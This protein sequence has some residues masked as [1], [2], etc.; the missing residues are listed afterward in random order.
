MSCII[1]TDLHLIKM[2]PGQTQARSVNIDIPNVTGCDCGTNITHINVIATTGY[3]VTITAIPSTPIS[4]YCGTAFQIDFDITALP[5]APVN[6]TGYIQ[7]E[8]LR[9]SGGTT[10]YANIGVNIVP[11]VQFPNF[12]LRQICAGST[13]YIRVCNESDQPQEFVLSLCSCPDFIEPVPGDWTHAIEPCQCYEFPIRYAP[14]ISS[15]EQGSCTIN[16]RANGYQQLLYLNY[17]EVLC[18]MELSAFT[19]RDESDIININDGNFN[20]E[21]DIYELSCIGDKLTI[22]ITENIAQPLVT[23]D[24]L[25]FG[26]WLFA[27]SPNWQYNFPGQ[28]S[29]GYEYVVCDGNAPDGTFAMRFYGLNFAQK[30]GDAEVIISNNG[31]T[32]EC[33]CTFVVM[34]DVDFEPSFLPVDVSEMLLRSS[35]LSNSILSNE[36]DNSVYKNSKYMTWACSIERK[37]GTWQRDIFSIKARLN[38]YNEN[39]TDTNVILS[40]VAYELQSGDSEYLSTERTTLMRIDFK[41]SGYD[42]PGTPPDEMWLI[43]IRADRNI[44]GIDPAENYME[45]RAN[46]TG[47]VADGVILS[48]NTAPTFISGINYYAEVE[49]AQV[50][51]VS[52][53]RFI[54][55][56][57]SLTTNPQSRSSIS[58]IF[59]CIN[60]DDVDINMS[61]TIITIN[62][63]TAKRTSRIIKYPVNAQIEAELKLKVEDINSSLSSKTGGQVTDMFQSLEAIELRVSEFRDNIEIRYFNPRISLRQGK[64]VNDSEQRGLPSFVNRGNSELLNLVFPFTI[65]DNAIRNTTSE[66]WFNAG[67]GQPLPTI[68][69]CDSFI[70]NIVDAMQITGTNT[71]NLNGSAFI[72]ELNQVWVCDS[73]ND[74]IVKIDVNTNAVLGTIALTIGDT[75]VGIIYIQGFDKVYVSCGGATAIRIINIYTEAVTNA[76]G[77][78]GVSSQRFARVGNVV[79]YT[80]FTSNSVH[81]INVLNDTETATSVVGTNPIDIVYF[82]V[83]DE[84]FVGNF[85]SNNI[86]RLDLGLTPAGTIALSGQPFRLAVNGNEVLATYTNTIARI[87]SAYVVTTA[88]PTS[89]VLASIQLRAQDGLIYLLCNGQ[90]KLCILDPVTLSAITSIDI[91][92]APRDF[93]FTDSEVYINNATDA[94]ITPITFGVCPELINSPQFSFAFKDIRL[95]WIMSFSILGNRENYSYQQIL[96]RVDPKEDIVIDDIDL[97]ELDNDGITWNPI[98]YPCPETGIMRITVDASNPIN[99]LGIAVEAQPVR[100][101]RITEKSAETP[102]IIPVESEYISDLNQ[103]AGD[104]VQ[105]VFDFPAWLANGAERSPGELYNDRQFNLHILYK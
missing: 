89:G 57:K 20:P 65:P 35:I 41:Y 21:C 44:Q 55:I 49:I 64:W 50:D 104:S 28:P 17:D 88:T 90:D 34:A 96:S 5:N 100:N 47:M 52:A 98:E 45:S 2:L 26:Q 37:S 12:N 48:V 18:D 27:Q 87:S 68:N 94:T 10:L 61:S 51:D 46:L 29:Q 92:D 85:N 1:N 99:V 23:G 75:P 93:V 11:I 60:Y 70:E 79:Y 39:E 62:D 80:A 42:A 6:S 86:T 77:I 91:G 9:S 53:Y 36:V 58:N 63:A 105:F 71:P 76:I 31:M 72:N 33:R 4:G 78:T 19:L 24:R 54:L 32:I 101:N 13:S 43:A 73:A 7:F 38:F 95:T 83:T 59:N 102:Y 15:E 16:I 30:N 67:T 3:Q 14:N 97:E 22:S 8:M 25:V 69:E 103:P 66:N 56:S 82:P 81:A 74:C 40:N 84:I